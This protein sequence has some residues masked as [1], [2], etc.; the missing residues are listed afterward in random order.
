MSAFQI[1]TVGNNVDPLSLAGVI[2]TDISISRSKR[3][4]TAGRVYHL[5]MWQCYSP[6]YL[7]LKWFSI[8]FRVFPSV[9][10]KNTKKKTAAEKERTRLRDMTPVAPQAESSA[11][12]F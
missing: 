9:S 3:G 1:P 5:F 6:A 4:N 8:S 11:R 10:T 12:N 2:D 7:P